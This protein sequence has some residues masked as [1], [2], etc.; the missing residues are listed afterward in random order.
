MVRLTI[1]LGLV[2]AMTPITKASIIPIST[3][4]PT[5]NGSG[6]YSY[7]YAADLQQDERLDPAATNG[8]TCLSM[9]SPI[10]CNPPGTFFTIYDFA[11]Y[12]SSST[13]AAGWGISTQS[14]GLTPST[15]LPPDDG[16]LTNI[17]FFYTG[18]VV[19]A[20]GAVVPFPGFEIV[21][22][23]NTIA[24]GWYGSQDTNDVGLDAGAT[25][26]TV[27]RVIVPTNGS[28]PLGGPV[29]EPGAAYMLLLGCAAVIASL[30][31][32]RN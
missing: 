6:G 31:R 18:A 13:S 11:G 12:L 3:S 23:L 4:G 19:H 5:A 25:N 29:P 20:D 2:I 21:S 22:S 16:T 17:T 15:L 14:V 30:R 24:E 32:K 26:Q 8:V 28:G 10:P 1:L 27:G 7:A 9:G